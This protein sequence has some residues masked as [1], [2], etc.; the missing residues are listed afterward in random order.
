MTKSEWL[1]KVEAD[2]KGQPFTKLRSTLPGGLVLEPLYAADDVRGVPPAGLPGCYPYVRGTAP[3]GGWIIQQEYDDPRPSVCKDQIRR[4]LERGAEGVWLRLGPRRG[5]RVLTIAELDEVLATVDLSRTRV[6]VD[7]GAD[8]LAVASGFLALARRREVAYEAL[9]GSLGVDPIALLAGGGRI[10]GG[11]G[12]R[13]AELRDLASWCATHAPRLQAVHISSAPY[14]GGGASAVQEIAYTIATGIEYLRQLTE[15][16]LPVDAA[17]RQIGFSYAARGD[18]FAEIAKLRAAR[19]LWAKVVVKAGGEPAAAG[20][21]MHCRTSLFTKTRRDPWVNMLRATAECT[22]A[23]L[24]GAQTIATVPFDCVIGPPSE[25]AQRVSRNTQIV[26]REE[27]HLDAVVDPA[28]G[29]WFVE[30]LTDELARAAWDEVRSIES[31]GGILKALGSGRIVD[32][33]AEVAQTR[34]RDLATRKTPIVGV[35]EFPNLQEPP[36]ER[37]RLTGEV[38]RRLLQVSLDSLDPSAQRE[39]L[40]ALARIAHDPERDQGAL[41]ESCVDAMA[42]GA[43]IYSVATVLQHGQPDFHLEPIPQWRAAQLWEQLRDRADRS[44]ARPRAFLANLGPIPSH[45]PRSTWARNLL[46]SAGIESVD[47]DGF[48]DME[49]LAAAWKAS[50]TSIA[51]ICGSDQDYEA[52]LDRAV[53]ALKGAGCPV[54]LLAGRPGARETLLREAGVSDF[55]FVGTDVLHVMIRA[56]DSIGVS[57]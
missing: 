3:A 17:A 37:D 8:A 36:V 25:L 43:D 46:A 16:G 51:V 27:S 39:N 19:G 33:V 6:C 45:N 26:L 1:A 42:A 38:L 10:E 31:D 24:G 49:A 47:N 55:V 48:D 2:L 34:H 30:R 44:P 5:C 53:A 15:A 13:F 56:L 52:M 9:A 29:S 40:L 20:M 23:V 50:S 7:G 54:L 35:S 22:A 32:S 14:E 57:R 11:L 18:F 12:A 41:T 4:D 21:Q 28:G